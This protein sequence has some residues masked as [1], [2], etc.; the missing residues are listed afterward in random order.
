MTISAADL[1]R[2]YGF[3]SLPGSGQRI[4]LVEIGTGVAIETIGSYCSLLG[5]VTPM[6]RVIPETAA[7]NH[8]EWDEGAIGPTVAGQICAA[9]LPA[10]EIAIYVVDNTEMGIVDGATRAITE[11]GAAVVCL[12]ISLPE[13]LLSQSA[14]SL[15]DRALLAAALKGVTVCCPTSLAGYEPSEHAP[16]PAS[17]ERVLAVGGSG[18]VLR[19]DGA[20]AGEYATRTYMPFSGTV[21]MPEWQTS[22]TK[23]HRAPGP[24]STGR[25][26]PD[27]VAC[28]ACDVYI[29]GKLTRVQSPSVS[30]I[31]WGA[32]LTL[33]GE[34]LGRPLGPITERLWAVLESGGSATAVRSVATGYDR[35]KGTLAY[36]PPWAPWTGWGS[37]NGE[38]MFPALRRA[39]DNHTGRHWLQIGLQAWASWGADKSPASLDQAIEALR[40]ARDI[41]LPVAEDVVACLD[42]LRHALDARLHSQ[43]DNRQRNLDELV[44]VS[45]SLIG[46]VD[47][48]DQPVQRGSRG[49]YLM[50]RYF[51]RG[52][53]D[54][55]DAAVV[56][57]KKALSATPAGDGAR[58]RRVLNVAW[59]SEIR[60]DQK[61]AR[62]E[63]P[64]VISIDGEERWRGPRDLVVPISQLDLA[65]VPEPGREPAPPDVSL[66]LHRNLGNLLVRYGLDVT[67]RPEEQ[68]AADI[69][70]AIGLL[71]DALTRSAAGSEDFVTCANSL[72]GAV[73]AADDLGFVATDVDQ[74]RERRDRIIDAL[75]S[76][77]HTPVDP[78]IRAAA[79]LNLATLLVTRSA[80]ARAP[81]PTSAPP[82]PPEP[83]R[84][85]GPPEPPGPDPVQTDGA[86]P[87]SPS[88]DEQQ[89]LAL[90]RDLALAAD[91]ASRISALQAAS[92]WASWA[93][94]RNA[95]PEV[96]TA[97]GAG[98]G[99]VDALMAEQQTWDNRYLWTRAAG[100]L[101]TAGAYAAVED[102]RP[103][104]AA[105]ALDQGRTIM[106]S[107]R[108]GFGMPA[109][110]SADPSPTPATRSADPSLRP[111]DRP[112]AYLLATASGGLALGSVDGGTWSGQHLPGLTASAVTARLRPYLVALDNFREDPAAGLRRW[113]REV[114]LSV[115]F[116]HAALAEFF[117]AAAVRDDR[118]G[119]LPLVI[120]PVGPLA[121][122][123]IAGA[124]L[125]SVGG[126][127][128][129][130]VVPSLR[131]LA[132]PQPAGE[133]HRIVVVR[134]PTLPS[135][136]LESAGA[137]AAFG[138][139]GL[140]LPEDATAAQV[141]AALPAD[142]VVHFACHA[143][144]DL[145]SPLFSHITL[146][147]GEHLAVADLLAA[148]FTP[149]R[150]AVLSACE[151]GVA[152]PYVIDE[153]IGLP[154]ALL[155]AGAHG[156]VATLWPVEDVSTTLLMLHFYWGWRRQGQ[157]PPA[158]L[159][160]AQ[161][162]LRDSSD[163]EK[164]A[165]AGYD[166]VNAGLLDKQSGQA[167]VANL[168]ERFAA[169][170]PQAFTHPY[171]WA[172]FFYSG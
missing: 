88:Q 26:L 60:Y 101:A 143:E 142:G 65:L 34:E 61:G 6:V 24:S 53:M 116:L 76:S 36:V 12:N 164:I 128:A 106:L 141:L 111:A 68:R 23:A 81:R 166:A 156:V 168:V 57:F 140:E 73:A 85:P 163:E 43:P 69:V 59:A 22:A 75:T 15:L 162:W 54:D 92:N 14:R 84:P 117:S 55:L 79:N 131:L 100:A 149:V 17:S 112:M 158:A 18:V 93:L 49:Y 170:G 165:F 89:A 126:G 67:K 47:L 96:S 5:L 77:A 159:A 125:A 39:I 7:R 8:D 74:D 122:L 80:Q 95:W 130:G 104:D 44:D 25:A 123:P 129:L 4:A 42:V 94:S 110:R 118:S 138:A 10:A 48:V 107:Q 155:L 27:V 144:V 35:D 82:G 46:L 9:L 169:L 151:S 160:R 28:D 91:P 83:P 137:M 105:D 167:M 45:A 161:S 1:S 56:D 64:R 121:L 86:S 19:T 139:A 134:D 103:G 154:A 135:T 20:V 32:L 113:L 152:D 40:T 145:G 120:V 127:L 114:N 78:V 16:Y 99:H 171:Y 31:L 98:Q 29:D 133:P 172:G 150:L 72:Y 115:D 146:P 148:P 102:D 87:A 124:A 52:A 51:L 97:H 157:P 30:T 41:G 132:R 109:T 13:N 136:A 90:Y 38:A 21:P 3:P 50:L 153:G 63:E 147:G 37:P 71:D 66:R 62:A 108:F 33:A 58:Y 11:S 70:R 2:I 119:G